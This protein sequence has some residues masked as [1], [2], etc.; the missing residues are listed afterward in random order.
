[1]SPAYFLPAD[2]AQGTSIFPYSLPEK[3]STV[4]ETTHNVVNSR[5]IQEDTNKRLLPDK[6]GYHAA[7]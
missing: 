7:G 6:T 1:M 2:R 3:Q 4:D 5:D